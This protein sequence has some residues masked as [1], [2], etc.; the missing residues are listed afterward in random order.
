MLRIEQPSI[1]TLDCLNSLLQLDSHVIQRLILG[2]Q[3]CFTAFL[4]AVSL[5]AISVFPVLSG[6]NFAIVTGHCEP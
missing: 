6:P 3:E 1:K 2:F 4:A 5:C